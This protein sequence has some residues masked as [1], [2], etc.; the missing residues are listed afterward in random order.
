MKRK[1][2]VPADRIDEWNKAE[3]FAIN[4]A[5]NY[6]REIVEGRY[7]KKKIEGKDIDIA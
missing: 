5:K 1:S 3:M 6:I 7:E 2:D 4:Q